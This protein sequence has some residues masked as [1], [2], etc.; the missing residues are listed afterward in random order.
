MK[1]QICK[2]CIIMNASGNFLIPSFMSQ[3]FFGE[4]WTLVALAMGVGGASELASRSKSF[5]P[6][7]RKFLFTKKG[8]NAAA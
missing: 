1:F 5:L 8:E 6:Q 4:Q 3:F 2:P 7:A